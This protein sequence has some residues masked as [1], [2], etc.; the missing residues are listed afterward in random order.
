MRNG[1]LAI[2]LFAVALMPL[3][4]DD[5]QIRL[6]PNPASTN[7]NIQFESPISGEFSVEVYTVLGTR[8]FVQNYENPESTV[9]V[10]LN[11]SAYADGIYLVRVTHG[12]ES[13]VKRIKIQQV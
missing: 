13:I 5:L 10:N 8:I 6:S 2:I 12:K 3:K 11:T 7:L 1:V 9:L 4:A